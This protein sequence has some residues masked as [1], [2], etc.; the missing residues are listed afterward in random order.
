MTTSRLPKAAE[1]D[2]LS[3]VLRRAGVIGTERVTEVTVATATQTLA[4]L[5]ARLLLSYDGV[6][7]AAPRSLI[8]KTA[9]PDRQKKGT[10]WP[11][12]EVTFYRDIAPMLPVALAP[13]C[14]DAILEGENWHLLLEDLTES[15]FVAT[16]WPLPPPLAQCEMVVSALA[17]F[18]HTWWGDPRLSDAV[19]S[20]MQPQVVEQRVRSL[21]EQVK[22]FADLLGDRLSVERRTFYA[23]FLEAAPRLMARRHARDRRTFAH[24]DAHPW[25]F[26]LPRD[27]RKDDVRLFDWTAWHLGTGSDDLAYM[28]ALHWYP[29]MRRAR[30]GYLLDRYYEGLQAQGMQAYE[31]E[32]LQE[33]YRLSVLLCTTLPVWHHGTSVPP[34][35]WWNQFERIHLAVE[36]LGCHEVL[37]AN[38]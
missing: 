26:F 18:H 3:E 27:G 37:A 29:E 2:Y 33:D 14:F 32:T 22:R 8:L 11:R 13:R 16:Q 7:R 28:M 6:A 9:R 1:P 4:S 10:D 38:R 34:V 19:E 35:V 25:N 5:I 31:R 24:G 23:H 36:D 17:R 15:H 12:Q 20:S 21:E 30:E